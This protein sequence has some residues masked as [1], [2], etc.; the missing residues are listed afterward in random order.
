M[1]SRGVFR[2][3]M[4]VTGSLVSLVYWFFIL[5][6]PFYFFFGVCVFLGRDYAGFRLASPLQLRV[7]DTR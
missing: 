2:P 3:K 5:F 4:G 6:F 7:R 1:I